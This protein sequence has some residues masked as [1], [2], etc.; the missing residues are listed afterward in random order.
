M[1]LMF[2]KTNISNQIDNA[3]FSLKYFLGVDNQ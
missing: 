2:Y 3:K 1:I